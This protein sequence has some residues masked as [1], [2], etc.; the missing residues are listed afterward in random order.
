MEIFKKFAKKRN[1]SLL[2]NEET[3]LLSKDEILMSPALVSTGENEFLCSSV[4][5]EGT[6]STLCAI[7]TKDHVLIEYRVMTEVENGV[8]IKYYTP[9]CELI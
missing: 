6:E 5:I 3:Y 2:N 4:T 8:D 1:I 7:E 9:N